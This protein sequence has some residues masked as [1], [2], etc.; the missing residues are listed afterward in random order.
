[1]KDKL[2]FNLLK[3]EKKKL[4]LLCFV[5]NNQNGIVYKLATTNIF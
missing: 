4:G 1:M 2:F 5:Y 3:I